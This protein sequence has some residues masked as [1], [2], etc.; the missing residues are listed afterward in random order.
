MSQFGTI[1]T[2]GTGIDAL[3]AYFALFGEK[4]SHK[5]PQNVVSWVDEARY[6]APH[7]ILTVWASGDWEVTYCV[8]S[9]VADIK[10]VRGLTVNFAQ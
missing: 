8:D 4:P 6:D 1:T 10:R 7:G 5:L 9:V 3:K 2:E